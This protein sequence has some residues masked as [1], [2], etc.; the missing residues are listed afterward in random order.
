MKK[1]SKASKA[2]ILV[3]II[4]IVMI[5][6]KSILEK[7]PFKNIR[8]ADIKRIEIKVSSP[9]RVLEIS[10]KN[11]DELINILNN[12][13]IYFEDYSYMKY[14][15]QIVKYNITTKNDG[16]IDI[17][18][19]GTYIIINKVSYIARDKDCKK[20]NEFANRLIK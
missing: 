11:I 2:F 9:N 1:A 12:T 18:I 16:R 7:K 10:D 19:Y 17:R 14:I 4:I 6:V 13:T 15:G 5:C 8:K 20:L 3:V